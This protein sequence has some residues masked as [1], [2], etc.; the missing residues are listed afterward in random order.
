M[1]RIL[2]VSCDGLGNGGVQA[3]MMSIVR[4]LSDEY[5]FDMLVFTNNKDKYDDEFR[6]Y[7]GQ[8]YRIPWYEGSSEFHMKLDKYIRGPRIYRGAMR[9]LRECG[10]YHAVHCHNYYEAA[11]ILSAAA[12]LHVP[13]RIAHIHDEIQ[14]HKENR[15]MKALYHYQA[16]RIEQLA[17]AKIGCAEKACK[18]FFA[19]PNN[20]RV[21]NNPYDE[22]RFDPD[23]FEKRNTKELNLLQIG[24]F[25]KKKNQLF[26]LKV[27]A[28]MKKKRQDVTLRFV[29]FSGND[30]KAMLEKYVQDNDLSD[31][32]FFL[33]HDA[34]TPLL[35]SQSAA[36]LLPSLYEGCPLV[37][38]ETQ[39]MGTRCYAS[40][41]ITRMADCGGMT[42]L[43]LDDGPEVWAETILADYEKTKGCY[44]PYNV[45][46][47]KTNSV[48]A[49]YRA[50]YKKP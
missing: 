17:T 4:S 32:V 49:E 24:Q 1:K 18:S 8:I 26:S 46:R 41:T 6:S 10:P 22:R 34:D 29:G 44:T 23:R 45:D 9:I 16:K 12:A 3:V 37:S 2:M 27:V 31:N 42:F 50:L 15:I 7:G 11:P 40:D 19:D 28:C 20:S 21:I 5:V 13:I 35:L 39:A 30:Y 33:P 36:M 25:G 48:A 14:M 38:L 47:F 43:S